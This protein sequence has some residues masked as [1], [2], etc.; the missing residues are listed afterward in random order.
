M[1][2]KFPSIFSARCFTFKT[3]SFSHCRRLL[4]LDMPSYM[5]CPTYYS[6]SFVPRLSCANAFS[7]RRSSRAL[8]YRTN[9]PPAASFFVWKFDTITP[10]RRGALRIAAYEINQAIHIAFCTSFKCA[11]CGAKR[12]TILSLQQNCINFRKSH[13][14]FQSYHTQCVCS[15]RIINVALLWHNLSLIVSVILYAQ[16]TNWSFI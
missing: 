10:P 16:R 5:L 8:L 2:F 12:F 11:S 3:I 1:R 14:I 7:K 4:S 13:H 15:R 9:Q 6:F